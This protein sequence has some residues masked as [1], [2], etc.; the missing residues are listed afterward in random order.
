M[1]TYALYGFFSALGAAFLNLILFFTGFHSDPAKLTAA[2]L[3]GGFGGL[4]IAVTCMV[5]GVKA[6][7]AE[8]PANEEFGYGRAVGAGFMVGLVSSIL[9]AIFTY[10]YDAFIN[11]G[12]LDIVSQDKLSKMEASGASSD[13]LEK[14]QAG[15]KFIMTPVLQS[16]FVIIGGVIFGLIIAL[17][18]GAFLRRSAQ[19]P[20]LS[21]QPPPLS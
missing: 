1:K 17:I 16:V 13:Q 8:I 9:S 3:I 11:P 7:R 6:R 18:V 4:A 2:S 14:A 21:P 19:A 12:F 10:A 15:M 20:A 5:L